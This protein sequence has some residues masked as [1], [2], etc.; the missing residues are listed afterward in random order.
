MNSYDIFLDDIE[1]I[2]EGSKA[3]MFIIVI[4]SDMFQI[5]VCMVCFIL[6]Y[7]EGN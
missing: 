1:T 4:V 2:A 7:F 6:L 3:T 5:Q